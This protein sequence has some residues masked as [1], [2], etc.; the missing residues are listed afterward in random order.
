[1][2]GES[3]QGR[4]GR[5]CRQTLESICAQG[6][7]MVAEGEPGRAG[8]SAPVRA[9]WPVGQEEQAEGAGGLPCGRARR[10]KCHIAS[11][12][13]SEERQGGGVVGFVGELGAK[14]A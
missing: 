2:A 3:V 13:R 8:S 14:F 1:M 5:A 7:R 12:S 10:R 4:M 11:V 6:D 9:G